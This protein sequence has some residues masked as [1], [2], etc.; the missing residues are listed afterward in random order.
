MDADGL[1]SASAFLRT[2][3]RARQ[4]VGM[5][6]TEHPITPE[7]AAVIEHAREAWRLLLLLPDGECARVTE[8]LMGCYSWCEV[9]ADETARWR[10][11]LL[12][13]ATL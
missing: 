2:A 12:T 7:G 5:D 8:Y 10:A 6:D 4:L 1:S 9:A 3:A 13:P 11:S